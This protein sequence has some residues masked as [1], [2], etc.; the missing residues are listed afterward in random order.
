MSPTDQHH[1][2]L[3]H[4]ADHLSSAGL[5]APVSFALDMIRPFDFLSSQL[6]LFARPFTTG[7]SFERYAVALTEEA[8]WK[9]L[10]RLLAHQQS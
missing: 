8:G 7:C 9:E 6:A 4:L 3:Q 2:A 5:R 1:E 10:R